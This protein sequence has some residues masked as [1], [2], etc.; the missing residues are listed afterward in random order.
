[1]KRHAF[2]L[3]E[4]LVVIALIALL[5]ALLFPAYRYVVIRGKEAHCQSQM[6]QLAQVI[7]GY[8]TR[9]DGRLPP[10]G[11]SGALGTAYTAGWVSDKDWYIDGGLL[12][13]M[14][15]IGSMEV[16]IC[17]IDMDEW[18]M[19][20]TSAGVDAKGN[21]KQWSWK[22][23]VTSPVRRTP[24]SS[25]RVPS[26]YAMNVNVYTTNNA[27]RRVEDFSAM[28]FLLVEECPKMS[29]C[30]DTA[31]DGVTG[32]KIATRHRDGGGFVACF[33]NHVRYMSAADYEATKT[34][35]PPENL[36][37]KHWLPRP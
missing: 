5:A 29:A 1:M 3:L 27:P 15:L 18:K 34:D 8:A 30:D 12:Y 32:D 22:S 26:S 35:M 24:G 23:L 6:R 25:G 37:T 16:L 7:L 11:K 36:K 10:P 19:E 33:D 31:I 14:E 9:N 2:T 20:K 21:P 4:L 17:P 28:G 13:T